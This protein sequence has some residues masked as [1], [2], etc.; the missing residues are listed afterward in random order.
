MPHI[1]LI[2]LMARSNAPLHLAL[3]PS[4]PEPPASLL[5]TR[6]QQVYCTL[7]IFEA[8][9]PSKPADADFGLLYALDES[10]ALY[11]WL[12]NTGVKIVVG[13]EFEMGEIGR[14]VGVVEGELKPVSGMPRDSEQSN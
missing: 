13:I 4:T 14:G 9:L 8:R 1:S 5:L 2:A 3:F 7:D 11:G 6:Q 10:L 12:T